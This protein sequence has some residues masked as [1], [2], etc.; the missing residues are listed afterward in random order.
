MRK[1]TPGE[2]LGCALDGVILFALL[3]YLILQALG[4]R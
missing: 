3:A 1:L 4:F 2:K